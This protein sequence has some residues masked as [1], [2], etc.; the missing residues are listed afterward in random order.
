[1]QRHDKSSIVAQACANGTATAC[2]VSMATSHSHQDPSTYHLHWRSTEHQYQR[3]THHLP[4]RSTHHRRLWTCQQFQRCRS[5][6]FG[7]RLVIIITTRMSMRTCFIL[8][9]EG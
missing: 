4:W 3:S 1:M 8:R 6:R 2:I 7:E 5:N 9:T